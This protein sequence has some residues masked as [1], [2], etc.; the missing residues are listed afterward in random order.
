M[1][2][3]REVKC[4]VALHP[5]PPDKDILERSGERVAT[6]KFSGDIGGRHGYG[7]AALL[8]DKFAAMLNVVLWFV[9]TFSIPPVIPSRLDDSGDVGLGK[10]TIIER[11]KYLLFAFLG[12]LDVLA[13]LLLVNFL[14]S[15]FLF[16]A[17][18]SSPVFACSSL[19]CL[20][21]LESS[22]LFCLLLLL[23][24]LLLGLDL[25]LYTLPSDIVAR[26]ILACGIGVARVEGESSGGVNGRGCGDNGSVRVALENSKC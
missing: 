8:L 15:L 18:A 16:A 4:L 1:V 5:M 2:A 3:T 19:R 25:L 10:R 11:L 13:E 9:E 7:E 17:L 14:R 6:V 22:I 12:L 23:L 21:R 20:L 24:S 26:R